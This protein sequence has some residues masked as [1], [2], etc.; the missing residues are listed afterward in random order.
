MLT[1]EVSTGQSD[2]NIEFKIFITNAAKLEAYCICVTV[3]EPELGSLIKH[4]TRVYPLKNDCPS[5][6]SD[7]D[8]KAQR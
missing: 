8:L 6:P 1:R 7:H 5:K 2:S 4:S 3:P